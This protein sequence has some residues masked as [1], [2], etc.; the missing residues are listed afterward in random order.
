VTWSFING[1]HIRMS[2]VR[3]AVYILGLLFW[4][5]QGY[6]DEGQTE[7]PSI[8]LLEFL[9]DGENIDGEWLDPLNMSEL[10]DNEQPTTQQEKPAND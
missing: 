5:V 1:W 2:R 3:Q 7:Q 10:H 6:T 4:H 9:G 8:E